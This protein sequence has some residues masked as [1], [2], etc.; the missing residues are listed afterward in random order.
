MSLCS[1]HPVN[2]LYVHMKILSQDSP[3][4]LFLINDFFA[5]TFFQKFEL[6]NSAY[7]IVAAYSPWAKTPKTGFFVPI[8]RTSATIHFFN[9]HLLKFTKI[10]DINAESVAFLV[11]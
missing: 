11:K 9:L 1:L 5:K 7:L 3:F 4:D 10:N 8:R 2:Q 6:Q